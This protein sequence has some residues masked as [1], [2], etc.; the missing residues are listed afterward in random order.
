MNEYSAGNSQC[1]IFIFFFTQVTL[2]YTFVPT[3]LSGYFL[4]APR[5]YVHL[6]LVLGLVWTSCQ[7]SSTRFLF[8]CLGPPS[9]LLF[10]PTTHV[11]HV[12]PSLTTGQLNTSTQVN[13]MAMLYL[14][15][16]RHICI[17]TSH[18]YYYVQLF[19]TLPLYSWAGWLAPTPH[20]ENSN[21][22]A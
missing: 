20:I 13:N 9:I 1:L 6:V 2:S 18:N 4:G 12:H 17:C 15:Y 16:N 5:E 21:C 10:V 19:F 11:S 7:L 8:V 14:I 3:Y 22:S